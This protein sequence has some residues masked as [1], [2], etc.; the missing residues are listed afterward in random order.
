MFAVAII[1]WFLCVAA[2]IVAYILMLLGTIHSI[3]RYK[4]EEYQKY[5]VSEQK[6]QPD[7]Y[8]FG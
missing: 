2:G 5:K 3:T 6:W 7:H 1:V 4:N 8:R